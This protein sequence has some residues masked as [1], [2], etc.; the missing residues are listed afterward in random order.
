MKEGSIELYKFE[1]K[2]YQVNTYKNYCD[3]ESKYKSPE[4]ELSA[5]ELVTTRNGKFM[6]DFVSDK[7]EDFVENFANPFAFISRYK[8]TVVVEKVGDK[9]SIKVF[10]CSKQREITKP[11]FKES[12]N[13]YF[14]TY[15]IKTNDIYDGFL[16]N[17]HLKRNKKKILRRNQ[18]WR[19]PLQNISDIIRGIITYPGT[20]ENFSPH[21]EIDK[22]ITIFINNIPNVEKNFLYL[23]DDMI[24][25]TRANALG[26]KLPD[27]W[28]VFSKMYPTPT[29]KVLKKYNFKFIDALQSYYGLNGGKFKKIFHEIDSI[30]TKSLEF[31]I[32]YF[33]SEFLRNQ[34]VQDVKMVLD[35]HDKWNYRY[36]LE[37]LTA[38]R[39]SDL[40][41][42]NFWKIFILCTGEN[43]NITSLAD[44]IDYIDKLRRHGEDV[45]FNAKTIHE[46]REEHAE[47]STLLETY[48]KGVCYRFYNDDFIQRLQMPIF[49]KEYYYPVVLT[50]T[51]EYNEES[52][53]QSNCVRG[54]VD[55]SSSIIVSLRKGD[56]K[57]KDRATIEYNIDKRTG[58][59]RA[60]NVQCLGRFNNRLSMEWDSVVRNLDERMSIL[61]N[62]NIFTL[63]EMVTKFKNKEKYQKA[64]FGLKG[65]V[66]WDS[67]TENILG[68]DLANLFELV[69]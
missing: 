58:K 67:E 18:F 28:Q 59:L 13:C 56:T 38:A 21:E 7:E 52:S 5:N 12:K 11:Y 4:F 36:L 46:F 42:N 2:V 24:F 66:V 10:L 22:I 35:Y 15:N 45:R 51:E 20:K 27:N 23:P 41:K 48:R 57:S 37:R 44:H 65:N 63:P 33:G 30:N 34:T 68:D 6:Q 62:S 19:Q 61:V 14:V 17:Y 69:I 29:K 32:D 54:Y 3:L 49:D 25:K 9:L 8:R 60:V 31:V 55:K 40:E 39:L 26:V 47:F 50:S 64:V 16:N 43:L 53:H 1:R